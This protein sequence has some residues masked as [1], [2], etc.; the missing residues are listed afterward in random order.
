MRMLIS[1][2]HYDSIMKII[3]CFADMSMPHRRHIPGPPRTN[4]FRYCCK[5][6]RACFVLIRI[7]SVLLLSPVD[8]TVIQLYSFFCHCAQ[9]EKFHH[10]I[11]FAQME[12]IF[13]MR[14]T[15]NFQIKCNTKMF[16]C[17]MCVCEEW[18]ANGILYMESFKVLRS[19][20]VLK[21]WR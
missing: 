4:I 14:S 7:F 5:M 21:L 6:Q 19:L 1:E 17:G 20:S 12:W 16:V 9:I 15:K 3:I 8:F 18:M 11:A 13:S 10:A 2:N